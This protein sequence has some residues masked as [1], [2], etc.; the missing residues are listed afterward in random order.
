MD[1]PLMIMTF[2][3]SLDEKTVHIISMQK[4]LEYPILAVGDKNYN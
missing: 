4:Y 3:T 2:F 1:L